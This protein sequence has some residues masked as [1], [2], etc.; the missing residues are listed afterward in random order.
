MYQVQDTGALARTH[1]LLFRGRRGPVRVG[2]T[3]LLL[4]V[5]SLLTDISA[6]MVATV[7]PLYLLYSVGL[8]PLQYGVLDGVYQAGAALVRIAGASPATAGAATRR[9]RPSGTACRRSASSG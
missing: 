7:L 4:G 3:V 6:E 2:R 5:V 1:R 8:T 9:S